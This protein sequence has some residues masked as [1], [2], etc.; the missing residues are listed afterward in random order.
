MAT[1]TFIDGTEVT[2]VVLDGS[3]TRRL[4][5]PS[6]ASVRIPI[7]HAIGDPGSRL[8]VVVD[9]SIWFHGMVM[10]ISDEADENT[11]YTQYEA[12]DP[13]EL[14][15]WRPVRDDDGDFTKP[16]VIENYVTGP[17]IIEAVLNN[18]VNAGLGPPEDAEGSLLLDMGSFD[19][20]V[21]D[22]T[23][24]PIDWPMTIAELVSLLISTGVVDV[25]ITPTDPGGGIMGTV[26]VY[27]GDYGNNLTGS[28]SFD[29]ATGS[30]NVRNVRQVKGMENLVNKIWY[31]LGPR[32]RTPEDPGSEQ[33]WRAN[34]QGFDGGLAY[35]P[36]G[37][38][39]DS[40]N[41]PAGPPWTDNQLGEKIYN[42][43]VDYG[44]RMDVQIFDAR[45]DE[46]PIG[47]DLYR[48][49]WQIESWLRAE[50]RHLVHITPAR[51][52]GIGEFDIGD[53][54]TVNAGAY[55]R[56]GFSGAQRI[57]EYTMNWDVNGTE[58]ITEL[59]TSPSQEGIV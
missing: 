49:L 6:Q 10:N 7:Q 34:I 1:Q 28:V 46:S 16:L 2:D 56:G 25:V 58:E 8:K 32:V 39:V 37:Q 48:R 12:T 30:Y 55:L 20:G 45:G 51:G 15:Q 9:S 4:N 40:S 27:N 52:V 59:Q 21:I 22:L 3:V 54:V 50:P 42:S 43:R 38:S 53:L 14:W 57:Y 41:N 33:H 47:R 23:G 17:Q 24:A 19:T 36:G 31:Y 11:G 26:N 5:R 29:F 18:S 13:M 35:P 44:V